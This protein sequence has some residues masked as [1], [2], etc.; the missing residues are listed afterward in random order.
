MHV[1]AVY[2]TIAFL[3]QT[4][5]VMGAGA[6]SLSHLLYPLFLGI[7]LYIACPLGLVPLYSSPEGVNT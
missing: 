3:A 1:S 6:Q 4:S 7:F 2:F 5:A